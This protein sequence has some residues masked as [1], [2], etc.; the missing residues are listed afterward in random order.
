[1]SETFLFL[2]LA[3]ICLLIGAFI[4]N[5]IANLK[6]KTIT[7]K[8]EARL[9]QLQDQEEKLNE[10]FEHALQEREA[11]RNEKDLLNIELTRR[12][13][14][15]DSLETKLREQKL[16]VEKLQEK[17]SNDFEVLANKILDSKSEK[18]TKQNKENIDGILKPLQEKIEKFEKKVD[19]SHKESIDR[20]A[21]LRQQIIGLK[22]LNE[23]MSKEATNL[24]KALKGDSKMQGNW[25]ELVLER[26]LEKSGLE[27][28]REYFMQNAFTN[29]E[30]KRVLPDVVLHLPDIKR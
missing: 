30:G 5:L 25:G 6:G 1:M 21:M 16:E 15:M 19:D 26:V 8:L 18:F 4:G 9:E 10:R 24:T 28:D 11:I 17:F 27:K 29:E 22:E 7:S 12:N 23:Q 3:A 14:E 13:S 2:L 20:H